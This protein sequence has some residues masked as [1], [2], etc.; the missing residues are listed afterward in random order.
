MNTRLLSLFSGLFFI[1]LHIYSQPTFKQSVD[2]SSATLPYDE[3]TIS[4]LTQ[5]LE[6]KMSQDFGWQDKVLW[7]KGIVHN[8]QMGAIDGKCGTKK[9]ETF[10]FRTVIKD[11][12]GDVLWDFDSFSKNVLNNAEVY[13]AKKQNRLKYYQSK[14]DNLRD[15]LNNFYT[16]KY[17]S[18]YNLYTN[19]CDSLVKEYDKFFGGSQVEML[20]LECHPFGYVDYLENISDIFNSIILDCEN[21]NTSSNPEEYFNETIENAMIEVQEIDNSVMNGFSEFKEG[22]KALKLRVEQEIREENTERV[23]EKNKKE[24]ISQ[25]E[26]TMPDRIVTVSSFVTNKKNKKLVFELFQNGNDEQIF[27][28]NSYLNVYDSGQLVSEFKLLI[29]MAANDD[30]KLDRLKKWDENLNYWGKLIK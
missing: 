15:S 3:Y 4:V 24:L 13:Q 18:V 28:Y 27:F 2:A 16:D 20:R 23:E 8:I 12:E 17:V 7:V 29:Y 22:F 5:K 21:F 25:L 11:I 9:G 19:K 30:Y 6:D 26:S 1:V 14:L 10:Y